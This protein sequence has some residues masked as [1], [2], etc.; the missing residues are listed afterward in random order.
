MG[1]RRADEL[2]LLLVDSE[3]LVSEGAAEWAQSPGESLIKL[4]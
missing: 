3:D 2:P 1:K 4:A